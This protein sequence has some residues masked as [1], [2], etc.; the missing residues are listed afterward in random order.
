MKRMKA[1]VHEQIA[2]AGVVQAER[3]A[4]KKKKR[5]KKATPEVVPEAAPEIEQETLAEE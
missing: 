1:R 3:A 4:E 5:M 2:Q